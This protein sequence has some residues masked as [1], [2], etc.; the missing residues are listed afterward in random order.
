MG[1]LAA[2][3]LIAGIAGLAGVHN[4]IYSVDFGGNVLL[5]SNLR[6]LNGMSIGIAMAVYVIIPVVE[7][8]TLAYRM[9]WV[10]VFLGGAGRLLSMAVLGLPPLPLLPFVC[11]E[12]LCPPIFI[13]WQNAVA[14]RF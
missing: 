12:V 1:I 9:V 4:P 10:A 6:F 7:K 8:Q 3:P 14:R 2:F 5:D 11:I 13:Y